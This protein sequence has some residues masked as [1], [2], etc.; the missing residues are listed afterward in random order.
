MLPRFLLS[1]FLPRFMAAYA[2]K[3]CC[4]VEKL[5]YAVVLGRGGWL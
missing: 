3:D 4:M 2:M 1:S 5:H